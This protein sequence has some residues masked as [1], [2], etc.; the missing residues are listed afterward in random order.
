MNRMCDVRYV[1]MMEDLVGGQ[2]QGIMVSCTHR[3]S[4]LKE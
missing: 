4:V 1:G 3:G 2:M